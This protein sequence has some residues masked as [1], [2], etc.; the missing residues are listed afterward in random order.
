MASDL[1]NLTV[2]LSLDRL[3]FDQG[4]SS[5]NRALNTLRGE[6]N[7]TRSGMGGF[8]SETER[9]SSRMDVLNRLVQVQEEK[10]RQLRASYDASVQATGENSRASQLYANQVNRASAELQRLQGELQ[11]TTE[12]FNHMQN[13]TTSFSERMTTMGGKLQSA[14]MQ[15]G[16]VFG[17]ISLAVG[18]ALKDA[19]S[20]GSEFESEMAK[21][22]S[23]AGASADEIKKLSSV[24][25][26]L[27]PL[28]GGATNAATAM[29]DLAAK[30]YSVNQI[31]QAMPGIVT[32]ANASGEDL[33]LTSET[34]TNALETFQ[35]KATQTG[36]VADV[37]ASAANK[38][39][40]GME[41]MKYAFNYAAAPAHALGMSLEQLSAA[42]GIMANAGIKGELAGTS[43]RAA[44]LRLADPPKAAGNE[45]H[46]LGIKVTDNSGKFR[47]FSSIIGDLNAKTA[48]MTNAQKAAAVST[49]FGKTAVSA[50]MAV[51]QAGKPKL[52]ALTQSL[53][54]S[55]GASKKAA[56][57]MQ[58]NFAGS[59]K[60]LNGAL[61]SAKI[62]IEQ[63]LSPALKTIA[64]VI[65]RVVTA[66][67]NLSPGMKQ[68]VAI[69]MAVTAVITAIAAVV[70]AAMAA[71][72]GFMIAIGEL[73]LTLAGIATTVGIVAGAVAGVAA[74][75][76]AFYLLYTR[77]KPVQDAINGIGNTIKGLI[78]GI[79]NIASNDP[80]AQG[81]GISIL[82]MIG[83]SPNQVSAII[84]G[85]TAVKSAMNS[86]KTTI[87]NIV[88]FV[89]GVGNMAGGGDGVK[90]I[91]SLSLLGLSS[92]Q[93]SA[94]QTNINAIKSIIN[95]V[96]NN[97]KGVIQTIGNG[98]AAFWK[99][100]GSQIMSF[101]SVAWNGIKNTISALI[102]SIKNIVMSVLQAIST[103][104]S[105][106]GQAI[107]AI[108][109]GVFGVIKTVISGALS[110]IS[111]LFQATFPLI[112]GVVE[113]AFAT[114]QSII[115]V[116]GDVISGVI[117]MISQLFTGDWNG[118]F[119]TAKQIAVNAWNDIVNT[120]K[121]IDLYQIGQDII[122][123]FVK[124][125]ESM[126]SAVLNTVKGIASNIGSTFHSAMSS[127][128]I[129]GFAGGTNNAP[130][131]LALVGE[132]G[133]ELVMLPKGSKVIP[134]NKTKQMLSGAPDVS[135]NA[136]SGGNTY[137]FYPQKA[138]ID[139]HDITREL[140][141]IEVLYG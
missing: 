27:A 96:L 90:G 125:I 33:A 100:N 98:I 127:L 4:L 136:K 86:V 49:I 110:F 65:Q 114:I 11:A 108:V 43:L 104:W 139:Q 129:P 102:T 16:M 48:N 46:A 63:A 71:V 17:G 99:A 137:N 58:N 77:C 47:D 14:G 119:N 42:T 101:V 41:D 133:P 70:G 72:G 25:Q 53:I 97:I 3:N 138:I 111:G 106:Y 54:N 1:R 68:F 115:K 117:K 55:D 5:I 28:A 128:H 92:S 124:G 69:G 31:I 132:N 51:I 118:A 26:Q 13:T 85:V 123:G 64:D 103:L 82:D 39:A 76:A 91:I 121:G 21:V 83:L 134:T 57:A 66:F 6:L 62:G 34:I 37:L 140:Q 50:M 122:N 52:D 23:K 73:G 116:A 141:R 81:K 30:G 38:T 93:I 135:S 18:G 19:I 40:A 95:N 12:Q 29:D 89:Q 22:G 36:H 8:E 67:N 88:T 130:G 131:G 60:K 75:G 87:Q 74:L 32:A 113:V 45:L 112:K 84:S 35:L 56:D 107:L 94:I 61:D 15:I 59:M 20:T 7:T 80:S 105:T 120:F 109:N 126:G 10:V 44:L 79:K 2:R 78:D 9:V 24:A